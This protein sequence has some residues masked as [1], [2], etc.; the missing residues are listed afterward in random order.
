M[1]DGRSAHEGPSTVLRRLEEGRH[2]R[3]DV[4]RPLQAALAVVGVEVVRW[5]GGSIVGDGRRR[6]GPFGTGSCRCCW[7]GGGRDCARV[8][9][10]RGRGDQ[11]AGSPTARLDPFAVS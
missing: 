11:V 9:R 8:G 5:T 10:G 4:P 1:D 7:G 2:P 3:D 6:Y